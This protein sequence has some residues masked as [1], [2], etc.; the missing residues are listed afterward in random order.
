MSPL[1]PGGSQLGKGPLIRSRLTLRSGAV[2][3]VCE[4][5]T[6]SRRTFPAMSAR[7]QKL[8]AEISVINEQLKRRV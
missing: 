1:K 4:S 8:A 2:T 3:E 5:A 7:E 6:E